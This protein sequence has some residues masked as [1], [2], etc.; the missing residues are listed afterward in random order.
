[1]Q[2]SNGEELRLLE[3]VHTFR[4]VIQAVS[5]ARRA[6]LENLNLDLIYGL[7]G[8]SMGSWQSTVQRILELTPDHISAYA[9]TFE[10]GTAFG[11]WLARGLMPAP[12]SDLA[13]DMYEWAASTFEE[14]GLR[15]YE[16]SNWAR[17]GRTCRH[18]LQYWRGLP[19]LGVGAGAHGYASG[20]RYSNVLSVRAY[21]ERLRAST[22]VTQGTEVLH[23]SQRE[24]PLSSAA[25]DVHEQ[26]TADEM[27][28]Y[29]ITGLR[30]TNEGISSDDFLG[31]FGQ[32][33]EDAYAKEL[34]K[35]C[36]AGLLQ[37]EKI[38]D[39]LESRAAKRAS[40]CFR[41]RLTPRGRLLGNRVFSE[42]LA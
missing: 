31:R 2:S 25:A 38:D 39:C 4:E 14:A 1:V 18:N 20:V 22:P 8:Q 30:L 34:S 28:D 35:L 11:R 36:R 6:G 12:D 29:M 19:Y 33:L 23:G 24:F 37:L 27:K 10:H 40:R 13:A 17:A 3:R 26:S 9:L 5:D 32:P 42:F 7:P 21:I 41:I 15:Q 16:I